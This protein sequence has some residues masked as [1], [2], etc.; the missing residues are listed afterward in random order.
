MARTHAV[1]RKS[2]TAPPSALVSVS[3]LAA[4][5]GIG[6]LTRIASSRRVP[7]T[8]TATGSAGA[9]SVSVPATAGALAD[10]QNRISGSGVVWYHDF[11]QDDEVNRFRFIGGY[12]I[13]VAG[14]QPQSANCRRI[15]TDGITGGC[16]ELNV[17][18]GGKCDAGWWRPFSP[19]NASSNGRGSADPA[20]NSSLTLR[21]YGAAQGDY[22]WTQGFYSHSDYAAENQRDGTDFWVQVRVKITGN[23]T[24]VGNPD[25]KLIYFD[26]PNG[27][28]QEIV[29]KSNQA[30][31]FDMYSNFG[32]IDGTLWEPQGDRNNYSP[33]PPASIRQPNVGRDSC[34]FES[35][36]CSVNGPGCWC[37]PLDEWFTLLFHIVPGHGTTDG[38][39]PNLYD[40]AVTTNK[41]TQIEVWKQNASESVYTK[42]HSK[43]NYLIAFESNH[44]WNMIKFSAYMNGVNAVSGGGWTHRL[45]QIIFSKNWIPPAQPIGADAPSW[46]KAMPDKTWIQVAA[47]AG[48]TSLQTWQRGNRLTDVKPSPL[49]AGFDGHEGVCNNWTGGAVDQSRKSLILPSNGGH[50]GYSGNEIYELVLQSE[51]P[52]WQRVWGPGTTTGGTGGINTV[53]NNSDGNPRAS[54]TFKR[55]VV[56]N[57]GRVWHAGLDSMY[58]PTGSWTSATYAWRRGDTNWTYLG[59]GVTGLT[60]QAPGDES[61]SSNWK[62]LGG[63]AAYD[64]IDNRIYSTAQYTLNAYGGPDGAFGVDCFYNTFIGPWNW[65]VSTSWSC[66]CP[67][68]G[69]NGKSLL[70]LY[71][72]DGLETVDLGATVAN[73]SRIGRTRSGSDGGCNEDSAVG[74]FH[75]KSRA[76][77]SWHGNGANIM[78]LSIPSSLSSAWT[79]STVTPSGSNTVTPTTPF[80]QGTFGKFGLID[81]M[82]NGQSAFVLINKTTEA[83][84]V[85]KIPLAGL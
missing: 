54:H 74:V 4:T 38:S 35:T 13:D 29:V 36:S 81:D 67:G 1:I 31:F 47:G 15:T 76:I 72:N 50:Q 65:N 34:T 41:D 32:A 53:G 46:F 60:P 22:N 45:G 6:D 77:F 24:A 20:A 48:A 43:S 62:L 3:G 59:R 55:P 70:V 85:Y 63:S 11:Q 64:P 27:S 30:R 84:F 9:L 33:A 7:S 51:N 42:I 71:S 56:S 5:S 23:R 19:L 68:L 49:P 83:A 39:Y 57:D 18:S 17:P 16:L 52:A 26:I 78:K 2:S 82:G 58:D 10:W 37:L 28:R 75:A 14:S 80:A 12:G 66:V 79:W 40:T 61:S 25:G 44:G 21:T 8:A 73:G 69:T